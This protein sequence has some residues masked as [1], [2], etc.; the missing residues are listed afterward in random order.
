MQVDVTRI[1]GYTAWM[2]AAAVADAVGLEV[3]GHCAP[4]LHV[5]VA[6]AAQNTRHLEY[7][8]D[9]VRVEAALFDGVPSVTGGTLRADASSPGHGMSLKDVDAE[10][11][12]IG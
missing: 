6:A 11:Y 4:A 7:F 8:V 3:S 9:H 10:R 1:G 12:R 5:P 2:Q